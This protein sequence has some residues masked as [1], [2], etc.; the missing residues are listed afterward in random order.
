VPL[1]ESLVTLVG[2]LAWPLVALIVGLRLLAELKAGLIT[3]I[4]NVGGS[5]EYA[6]LR[7]TVSEAADAK[8]SV[9]SAGLV[10]ETP[11]Y[12]IPA[13]VG[14]DNW[15][16]NLSPY[17]LVMTSWNDLATVITKLAALHNGYEDKR[18]VW[19]NVEI[20]RDKSVIPQAIYDAVR[21]VQAA[22][23]SIRHTGNVDQ[24]TAI[25]LAKSSFS[26]MKF[27]ET[28]PDKSHSTQSKPIS[29]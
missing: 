25:S 4:V 19:T 26:L 21:S 23:N 27:F 3:K 13:Q 10:V 14:D 22:R 24:E 16:D 28:I 8:K 11:T 7:L 9:E 18:Q 20:L 29:R 5:I 2:H 17:E 15:A 1:V 6:G 12:A